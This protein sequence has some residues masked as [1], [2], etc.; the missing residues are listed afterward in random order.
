MR[1]RVVRGV[2]ATALALAVVLIGIAPAQAA[3]TPTQTRSFDLGDLDVSGDGTFEQFDPSLGTLTAV[4]LT[5]D[6]DLDFTVC[7][8]NL[9]QEA[10]TVNAGNATGTSMV[11]FAGETVANAKGA[12]TVPALDLA[13]GGPDGCAGWL[14]AGGNPSAGP[15]GANSALTAGSDSKSWSRIL[16]DP[17]ALKPYIGT[18]TVG[19]DYD[20]SSASDLAQPAEWTLVFLAA[21]QGRATVSY[22]YEPGTFRPAA[23]LP[24]TGGPAGWVGPLGIGLV[25]LGAGLVIHVIRRPHLV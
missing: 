19:F 8:T 2:A 10:A 15:G 20:A 5:T 25:L 6:V 18:G 23:G 22:V 24:A 7:V 11:T 14:D 21:G 17:A 9:S 4:R 1:G 12:L 16:T 13:A 3:E